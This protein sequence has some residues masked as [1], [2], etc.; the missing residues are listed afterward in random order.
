M[1]TIHL[2]VALA[3]VLAPAALAEKAGDTIENSLGMQLALVP[4]GTFT[5][6]S[7]WDAEPRLPDEF[8]HRVEMTRAFRMST[9]E[10]TQGQY[11][12]IMDASPSYHPGEDDLPVEMVGWNNAVEFCK[13]LS[14]KEGKTYRLPTEAEWEYACRAGGGEAPV[15][16]SAAWYF[17]TSGNQTHPVGQKQANAWGLYDMLGNVA[18]WCSDMY[19]PYPDGATIADPTGAAEGHAHVVRGGGFMHF[20]LACRSAARLDEPAAYQLAHLGFR[21]VQE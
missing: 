14:S 15:L 20:A 2:A 9:T 16:K 3:L 11:R 5:M 18:E 1:K 12:A 8:P 21:V 7:A 17:D 4:A 10:V 19:G 6:G 13:R